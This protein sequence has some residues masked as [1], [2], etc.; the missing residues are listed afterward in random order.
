MSFHRLAPFHIANAIAV[1]LPLIAAIGCTTST[2]QE[3]VLPTAP[4]AK[5]VGFRDPFDYCA[6]VGTIDAP[7]DR[8]SGPAVTEPIARGLKDAFEAPPAAPLAPFFHNSIWRCM[9]G[10]VYACNRGSNLPCLEKADAGREPTAAMN[11]FCRTNPGADYIPFAAT[12]RATIYQW[13]CRGARPAIV[14]QYVEPDRRGFLSNVW[15]EIPPP[16]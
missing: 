16:P 12:G 10:R 8:Y 15:H 1:A 7:D 9:D 5:A 13:R 11:A 6:A 2:S 3:T 4:V 14:K